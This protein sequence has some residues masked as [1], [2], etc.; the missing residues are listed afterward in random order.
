MFL[1]LLQGPFTVKAGSTTSIT[2]RNVFPQTTAFTFQVDNP[3]FHIA[4]SGE[5][6]RAR[7]E[8]RIVVG[9]DG[10]D[11]SSKATV[12]GKLV[13]SC[14]R[15]AGDLANTQWVYYLKGMTP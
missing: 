5:N 8:H 11:G 2:F 4:K 14:A 10:N 9:F 7:K 12:M 15:S 13:V 3:L 1:F 6:V